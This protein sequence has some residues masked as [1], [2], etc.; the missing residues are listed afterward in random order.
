MVT[1]EAQV[2]R[3]DIRQ[4]CVHFGFLTPSKHQLK[5]FAG[6]L[7]VH[8]RYLVGLLFVDLIQNF[9]NEFGSGSMSIAFLDDYHPL[10]LNLTA[11]PGWSECGKMVMKIKQIG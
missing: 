1:C 11:H 4:F 5:Y 10:F 8:G 6:I 9:R 2:I 3:W 7:T